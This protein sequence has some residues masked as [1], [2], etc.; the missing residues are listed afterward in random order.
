MA[1]EEAEQ[2]VCV[3]EAQED[4]SEEILF[5]RELKKPSSTSS[6]SSSSLLLLSCSSSHSILSSD[7]YKAG[8]GLG[9]GLL[10]GSS[11]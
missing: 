8:R 7:G 11:H 10:R 4:E 9:L 6:S 3:D 2:K 1:A 5:S